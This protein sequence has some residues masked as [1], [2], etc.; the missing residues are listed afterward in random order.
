MTPKEHV[1]SIKEKI[2]KSNEFVLDS[3]SGAIDRLQKAFPRYGSFLMEFIQNADDAGSNSLTIEINGNCIKIFNDGRPFSKD[4]VESICKVG[5]SSKTPKD[6]IGYLGV[7]FKAVFLISD[8]PEI[9]SGGYHFKFDKNAWNEPKQIP[10]QVIPIWIDR[11]DIELPKGKTTAFIVPIRNSNLMSKLREEV[12]E[13]YLNNRILLFLRNIN[14]IEIIDKDKNIIRKF[15]KS[16]PSETS[17]YEI[18]QIQEY[19]ND[20]L[21]YQD[22]WLVFRSICNVP[23]DVKEDSMT[24]EWE[25]DTVEKREILV[26]FKLDENNSLIKEQKGTAHIGVFSFLPLKEVPSGLNFLIQADFLTT[27]GRSELARECKWNEWLA[28]EIY[29]LIVKK[30]IPV[31]LKHE[32]WKMN[33]T[34][35]LYS[36]EGGH[37]L[38]EKYIK[39]PLNNYLKNNAVLIAQDGS[40]SKAEEL[41][42]ISDKKIRDLFTEDDLKLLYP[43]KKLIH[44]KCRPHDRLKE[45]IETISDIYRL[46]TSPEFGKILKEKAKNKDTEWFNKLYSVLVETYNY[47]YFERRYW[48]YKVRHDQFW[49][50]MQNLTQPIILTDDYNLVRINECYVNTKGIQI[51]KQLKDKLKIVHPEIAKDQR[52]KRFKEKLNIDRLREDYKPKTEV[53]KELT[54]EEIK[55]ALKQQEISGL[56]EET[57]EKL[58][59]DEKIKK[60]QEIKELWDKYEIPLENYRFITI[61]SKSGKW[62]K[63]EELVFSQEYNPEHNLELLVHKDLIDKQL[64]FVSPEFIK[65]CNNNE[66]RKWREFFKK[67]G[68]DKILESEKEGGEKERLVQRIGILATIKYEKEKGRNA[69]ELGESEKKGYD[70]ESTSQDDVRYIEVKSTSKTSCDIFL[71]SNELKALLQ[72]KNKYYVYIVTNVLKKPTVHIINGNE[73]YEIIEKNKDVKVVIP[74]NEWRERRY[75]EYVF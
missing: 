72:N 56:D 65:D 54:D 25:R 28:K 40:V 59:D 38:F 61:K 11:P 1:E 47:S 39:E 31:F 67:L 69:Q 50:D 16:K 51:P 20:N 57:W 35:I 18:Y 43:D 66:I 12:K 17:D 37:E 58:S 55:T 13:E 22:R 9:H 46:I 68:V 53:L 34:E 26:A 49:N 42:M 29:N 7:G 52:F 4:D 24:K 73:L 32:E 44:D 6:Y 19:R 33:F 64:E 3:L 14:E 63:P 30:C 8:C 15:V 2:L 62:L 48:D 60:I 5:R 36:T 71:T 10:W 23:N 70:I 41:I 75:D 27:P 21:Q 74:F 45:K